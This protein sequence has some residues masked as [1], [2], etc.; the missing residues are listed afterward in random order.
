LPGARQDLTPQADEW[1]LTASKLLVHSV[2]LSEPQAIDVSE[3]PDTNLEMLF[4]SIV[5]PHRQRQEQHERIDR[6]L[7]RCLGDELASVFERADLD[8]FGGREVRVTKA[9]KGRRGWVVLEGVN[10]A[11]QDAEREMDATTCRLQRLRRGKQAGEIEIILGYIASP[12][13]LNGERSLVE[14]AREMT[15]ANVFDVRNDGVGLR[16]AARRS[17]DRAEGRTRLAPDGDH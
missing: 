10:L 2:R 9:Y 8:G 14:F 17:L 5:G 7:A 4:E 12:H 1:W 6:A 3:D 13:G 16:D 15:G 11:G